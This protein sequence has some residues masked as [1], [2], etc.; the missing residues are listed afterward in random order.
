MAIL[1]LGMK[2]ADSVGVY[3]KKIFSLSL[4]FNVLI[5]LGCVAGILFGFYRSF[6]YWRPYA[7]YLIDGNLFW[8]V[9]AAAI[10]NIFPSASIGRALHTGRFMFHHYVYGFF[11]LFS[12]SAFVVAFTS[13]SL[14]SLFFVDTNNITVNAGRFFVL[15]GLTLLLDDLPDVSK[16]VESGLN[17]LKSK[18]YQGRK[19][20]HAFQLFTGFISFYCFVA[21]TICTI[22][23]TTRALPNSFLIS[24]LLITSLTSF[25]C[26]KRKAWLKIS[27][28]K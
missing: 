11:V 8:L 1:R 10:V 3:A 5:T 18:A 2:M 25:A 21:V 17:W 12:S 7:P 27:P 13:V 14:F 9:I 6:P 24:T 26:V 20:I 22:Q 15:A 19:V 4:I 23:N 28:A 16:R